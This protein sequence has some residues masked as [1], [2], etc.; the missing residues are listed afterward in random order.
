MKTNKKNIV[1]L[2]A[3]LMCVMPVL[4]EES[5]YNRS[6]FT[7]EP[8]EILFIGSSYFNYNNLPGLFENLAISS[9]N[10][11]YIDQ[12]IPGGLYLSDHASSSITEV[13]INEKDWDYVILQG[14]G[15]VT[16]YPDSFTLHPVYPALVT[17]QNK[18]HENCASTKM[19][20]CLPWAFEDGMTWYGWPDTYSD[21]QINIYNK[22]LLYS[23]DLDF[24]I[25]PVG[26]AWYAVLDELNYPLHY[27]HMSDWNHPSL[28]GSYLMACTIF[29]AIFKESTLG[30]EYYAGLP[31]DEA[32]YFQT[33]ASNTVL[34]SLDLWNI[35]TTNIYQEEFLKP[36]SI[37]LQ[38]NYPNPFNPVTTINY[39]IPELSFVTINVF[40]VLGNEIETLVNEEKPIGTHT[41][42][43][44]ASSLP[45]GIYFY[46][47]KT[48]NITQT[49]KMI[50]L[51]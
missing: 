3:L 42:E 14:V 31:E 51:K 24:P 40:D 6:V 35:T 11:V 25:A 33:V 36:N 49:K 27:L 48:N 19:V 44:D 29:S 21:M 45:S 47:L 41:I 37:R 18:I 26:W 12:Y 34:D 39:Q 20:F 38:Q 1:V 43:F 5:T 7:Q 50:L 4:A 22:T 13:K 46:Q 17:L 15:R 10:E 9:G 30:N 8:Y 16:A 28:R 2:L 23:N 32:N